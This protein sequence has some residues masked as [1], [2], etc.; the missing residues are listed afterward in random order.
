MTK[1]P[2]LIALTFDAEMDAFDSSIET[3]DKITW[4]GIEQGI[5]LIDDMLAGHNDSF[6][7]RACAT[8][9]VRCDDQ[10][11]HLTGSAAHLLETYKDC[12]FQHMERG[13]EIAFHP[14]LYRLEAGRWKQDNDPK[15]LKAQIHRTLQAMRSAGFQSR[16]SR[17]GE[18][19]G[20]NAVMQSLEEAGI[21]CDSTAMP[22]RVRVDE[23]RSLDWGSSP[24]FPY[25]PAES[26]YRVPGVPARKLLEVPMSM[27]LTS[28]DYDAVPIARYL[29]LSFHP[30]TLSQG[31][32]ALIEEATVIVTVTHPSTILSEIA[33]EPHGLLSFSPASF[34]E[35]LEMLMDECLQQ[36]RKFH[37]TTL[38]HFIEDES[39]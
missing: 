38:G 35:N 10:I 1:E 27:V 13:D 29:D 20:S 31:L 25:H 18:A 14:H 26:D 21:L 8:W 5:P 24:C 37:F 28:A 15:T 3:A 9:F 39:T 32:P 19:F 4:R 34:E 17:I 30:R 12:W 2:L 16:V 7:G 22:G 11:E 36:D 23:S 6:G 33:T